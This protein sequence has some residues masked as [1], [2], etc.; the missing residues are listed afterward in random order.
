M[1]RVTVTFD[2]GGLYV[3][4]FNSDE[5]ANQYQE[6]RKINGKGA[7]MIWLKAEVRFV[8]VTEQEK[9]GRDFC[10]YCGS[11]IRL[12]TQKMG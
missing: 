9:D 7:E 8:S 10:T 2:D 11:R 6:L 5:A 1:K 4:I 3:D 12:P